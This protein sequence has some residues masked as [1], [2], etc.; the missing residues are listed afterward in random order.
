MAAARQAWPAAMNATTNAAQQAGPLARQAVPLAK[1]AGMSVRESADDAIAW[2]T[3]YAD[4]ARTWAAPRLEE[5]AVTISEN[6]A[7]A[8]SSALMS[9]AKRIDPSHGRRRRRGRASLLAAGLLLLAAGAAAAFSMLRKGDGD[10][11]GYTAGTPAPGG[12]SGTGQSGT[13]ESGP[14]RVMGDADRAGPDAG[15]NGGS[16]RIT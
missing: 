3:P 11:F 5:S 15:A 1:S 10:D 16:S 2:A 12:K 9:A 14:G 6:I 4:A 13:G 8:I 7:P